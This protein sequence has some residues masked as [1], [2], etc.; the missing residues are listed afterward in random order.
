M[1]NRI[2]W[3]SGFIERRLNWTHP[4]R[5]TRLHHRWGT[6]EAEIF[7]SKFLPWPGFELRTSQSNG[8][9]RNDYGA[10]PNSKI[11]AYKSIQRRTT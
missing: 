5:V 11:D 8:R 2:G 4:A 1:T 10:T 9:E 3:Y 6:P 7:V